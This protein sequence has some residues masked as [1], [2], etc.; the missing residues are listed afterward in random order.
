VKRN[1]PNTISN[2]L[3]LIENYLG[4][5]ILPV[6]K[7]SHKYLLAF[8]RWLLA[9]IDPLSYAIEGTVFKKLLQITIFPLFIALIIA[10]GFELVKNG[11]TQQTFFGNVL[12]ILVI[13]VIFA[14]LERLMP[15]SRKWLDDKDEPVDVMIFF[16]NVVWSRHINGAIELAT[17]S[18]VV[19]EISPRIGQE[20]WPSHW[21][22][23]VQVL[24]L[25]CIQDFFRYWYH[26][27]MHE[28]EIMWRWHSV[29]HSSTRLY[30][31]NASRFH[32]IEG[33]VS[34][35]LWGIPLAYVQAPVEIVF[36]TR[37]LGRTLGRFQHSNMDLILGPFDYIFATPNN[38]RYHHSK[39]AEE[40]NSNYGGDV[41]IWDI[42]FGTFHLP[43]GK[44]PSD[45]IGVAGMP[46][47]PQNWI[48]LMLAPFTY[49]RIKEE[50]KLG[51]GGA[52]TELQPTENT[53]D[54]VNE[55]SRSSQSLH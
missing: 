22:P 1:Y 15:F 32:P 50:A 37:L 23:I 9:K 2:C 27:W 55:A 3:A 25:L 43:K 10:I 29:H 40:G 5:I 20:I 26:R 34:N 18:L 47:Y 31:F 35:L 7:Y 53:T 21:H 16:S 13:G 24:M 33:L 51:E 36:V 12:T 49:D 17:V 11:Y 4:R 54:R 41:I 42:L 44:K 14:P 30:W 39:K 45:D 46:N 28:N 52:V 6:E 48:G 19:Q 38:H 8:N